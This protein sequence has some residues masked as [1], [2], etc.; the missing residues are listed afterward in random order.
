[1]VIHFSPKV[2]VKKLYPPTFF[3]H[4]F[5]RR[6]N[7]LSHQQSDKFYLFDLPYVITSSPNKHMG[8]CFTIFHI[9][10]SSYQ[11]TKYSHSQDMID[12]VSSMHFKLD[13]LCHIIFPL[14]WT[15]S[16]T[17]AEV[18]V[19]TLLS[20]LSENICR[21]GVEIKSSTLLSSLYR[22]RQDFTVVVNVVIF[23]IS[24]FSLFF[25]SVKVFKL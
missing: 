4:Y 7:T 22:W 8:A 6:K 5:S 25:F 9:L 17:G 13:H 3:D 14:H 1:M 11:F 20:S 23:M 19:S 16:R 21:A 2:A 10:L 24:L 12:I 18:N 15:I